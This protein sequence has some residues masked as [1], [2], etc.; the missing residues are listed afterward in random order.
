MKI[1][2]QNQKSREIKCLLRDFQIQL[3]EG[4]QFSINERN[5]KEFIQSDKYKAYLKFTPGEIITGSNAL[6]LLGLLNRDSKDLDLII[7]IYKSRQFGKLQ[8]LMY[9][10]EDLENY[11]GTQF[12]VYHK[13]NSFLDIFFKPVEFQFDFFKQVDNDIIIIGDL[14]L[15]SPLNIIK[16][17]IQLADRNGFS[18]CKHTQDLFQI[19]SN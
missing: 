1:K 10:N 11:L 6:K 15:E 18:Y 12:V 14:K 19:L 5:Y 9:C 7:P 3:L 16:R 2:T 4:R 17:K 8:T 13:K